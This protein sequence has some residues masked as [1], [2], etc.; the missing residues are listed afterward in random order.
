[1]VDSGGTDERVGVGDLYKLSGKTE[2]WYDMN[3]KKT[4]GSGVHA[5]IRG[6]KEGSYRL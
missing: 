3:S 6:T 4:G 2:L 5:H 1:M